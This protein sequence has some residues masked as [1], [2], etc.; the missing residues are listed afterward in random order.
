MTTLHNHNQAECHKL[1]S[2]IE[3]FLW[4]SAIFNFPPCFPHILLPK[5]RATFPW[6]AKAERL[7]VVDIFDQGCIEP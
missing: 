2:T 6:T 7:L 5:Y 1:T 4:L 3:V